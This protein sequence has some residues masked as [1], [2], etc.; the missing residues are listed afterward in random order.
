MLNL[1]IIVSCYLFAALF[2]RLMG[3]FNAAADAISSWGRGSTLRRI[4]RR[5][6]TMRSY[7]RSRI[8]S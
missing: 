3:G 8:S 1:A 5:G 6:E 2:L 4:R 7:A